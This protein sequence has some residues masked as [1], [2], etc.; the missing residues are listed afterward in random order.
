M[1]WW[2]WDKTMRHLLS[3]QR[4]YLKRTRALQVLQNYAPFLGPLAF[5]GANT[6]PTLM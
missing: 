6:Q 4:W 2:G 5:R 3:A 1:Y